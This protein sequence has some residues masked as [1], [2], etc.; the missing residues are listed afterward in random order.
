MTVEDMRD[1]SR[2]PIRQ[3]SDDSA[4]TGADK[5]LPPLYGGD[6]RNQALLHGIP[7]MMA[8]LCAVFSMVDNMRFGWMVVLLVSAWTLWRCPWSRTRRQALPLAMHLGPESSYYLQLADGQ[9]EAVRL[10]ASPFL[11]PRLGVFTLRGKQGKKFTFIGFFPPGNDAWRRW[12]LYLRQEWDAGK[13][14]AA[15]VG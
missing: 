7:C 13:N 10:R 6:V 14:T 8:G 4:M 15:R 12:R 5:V 2:W 1:N 3:G 11:H 9:M